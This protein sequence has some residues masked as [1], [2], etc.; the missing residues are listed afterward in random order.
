MEVEPSVLTVPLRSLLAVASAEAEDALSAVEDAVSAEDASSDE[1]ASVEAAA[2]VADAAVSLALLL[3]S[4][5]L[6]E[7]PHPAIIVAPSIPA[8]S[9]AKTD[10]FIFHSPS[11]L[12]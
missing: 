7:L 12:V 8:K 10:F 4:V 11:D 5:V 2:S 1:A 3:L 6:E 9:T